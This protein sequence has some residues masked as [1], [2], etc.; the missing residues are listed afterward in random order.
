MD[1][2]TRTRFHK[3]KKQV[4]DLEVRAIKDVAQQVAFSYPHIC[5]QG[6]QAQGY[7]QTRKC[8]AAGKQLYQGIWLEVDLL[9]NAK[10]AWSAQRLHLNHRSEGLCRERTSWF[11]WEQG[12]DRPRHMKQTRL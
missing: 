10:H 4:H 11:D 9:C 5:M 6:Y 2:F 3:A 1:T 8:Q 12:H 7:K